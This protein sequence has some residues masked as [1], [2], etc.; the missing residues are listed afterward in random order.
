MFTSAQF[1]IGPIFTEELVDPK[2]KNK[3]LTAERYL[4]LLHY[5]IPEVKES[6]GDRFEE[7]WWQ[8][9]GA[10]CHSSEIPMRFLRKTF[11]H[12]LVAKSRNPKK[13][14]L[15]TIWP[16]Y[17][18]DLSPL[19]FFVWSAVRNELAKNRPNMRNELENHLERV[20]IGID[21]MHI[22]KS[23]DDFG[24]RIEALIDNGGKHFE[25]NL[26]RFKLARNEREEWCEACK[27]NHF[28]E[29]EGCK[30]HCLQRQSG[31]N[32][33]SLEEF[34]IALPEDDSE[35]SDLDDSDLEDGMSDWETLQ[36][37]D[38]VDMDID[39]VEPSMSFAMSS[40]CSSQV[41]PNMSVDMV[42]DEY[43]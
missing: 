16:P 3:N 31:L 33:G 6:F 9:D 26:R 5:V 27:D 7:C 11:G 10:F 42:S 21:R 18:P 30:L 39:R 2:V 13:Q 17:S 12:R 35:I 25:L 22:Y 38:I 23:L 1:T 41:D 14:H 19:D 4:E 37:V 24:V 29:C 34:G 40:N 8:Q 43:W 20:I 15:N 32:G 28:C 36:D